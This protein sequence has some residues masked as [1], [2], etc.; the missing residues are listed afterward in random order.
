MP[1]MDTSVAI[2]RAIINQKTT[3]LALDATQGHKLSYLTSYQF[4]ALNATQ[5]HKLSYPT[6]YQFSA[7]NATQGHKPSFPTSYIDPTWLYQHKVSVRNKCHTRTQVQLSTSYMYQSQ[8]VGTIPPS[9]INTE[10]Q[11]ALNATQVQLSTSYKYQSQMIWV[12]S[13]L[14]ISINTGYQD[15]SLADQI[16]DYGVEAL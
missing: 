1:H 4:S 9:C 8:M 5:G 16:Q 15:Y 14:V 7:L 10:F 3:H 6:S 13:Y 12:R 2:Q 11:S